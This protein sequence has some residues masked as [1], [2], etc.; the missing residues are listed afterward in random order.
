MM[1][2]IKDYLY[3]KDYAADDSLSIVDS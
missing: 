3:G 2:N 1:D